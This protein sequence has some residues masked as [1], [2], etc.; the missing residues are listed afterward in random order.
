MGKTDEERQAAYRQLFKHRIPES[1]IAEIRAATN[2]AWVLG[3]DRFKQRIQEKL[4][5]RVEPKARRING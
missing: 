2:K 1:S 3:N 4:D 5:R